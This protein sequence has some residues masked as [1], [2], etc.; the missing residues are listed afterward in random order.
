I[1][2]PFTNDERHIRRINKISSYENTAGL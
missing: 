1:E 2:T